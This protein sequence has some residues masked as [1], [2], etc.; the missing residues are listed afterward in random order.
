MIPLVI[1]FRK[2]VMAPFLKRT[3]RVADMSAIKES[4]DPMHDVPF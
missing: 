1:V 4:K 2:L 3:V